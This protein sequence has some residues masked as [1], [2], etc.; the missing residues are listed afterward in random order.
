M[1]QCQ[2]PG[3]NSERR[4]SG[5][6][7]R[8]AWFWSFG[9]VLTNGCALALSDDFYV[10]NSVPA[11]GAGSSLGGTTA[12]ATTGGTSSTSALGGTLSTGVGGTTANAQ[13]GLSTTA[14]DT[15]GEP[16]T[17]GTSS[18]SDTDVTGGALATGG[19]SEMGGDVGTGGAEET[20]GTA[21]VGG[22]SATGGSGGRGGATAT[23]GT[24]ATGGNSEYGGSTSE[25]GGSH[26]SGGWWANRSGGA[27]TGGMNTGGSAIAAT[28]GASSPLSACGS[29]VAEGVNCST[30]GPPC[31]KT[32]GPSG[33]GTKTVSCR[34]TY[35]ES[36][37]SFPDG[38]DY[39][40]FA[41]P[42]S[43]PRECP[44]GTIPQATVSCQVTTCKVCFGGT[45]TS[46]T[47]KDSTGAVKTGYC[48]CTLDGVW[49]C[50]TA[51]GSWPCPGGTGCT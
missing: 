35:Q 16:A 44:S 30:Y 23:G 32:C 28:G 48:V 5:G 42:T 10:E 20:G 36:D 25:T 51:P 26:T 22:N 7:W 4:S 8:A 39:S 18:T 33:I 49:T 50:G 19:T 9:C 43:L 24:V 41:V 15:G 45:P 47:Y 29:S 38:V 6:F 27:D 13:G 31:I 11:G 2:L 1:A 40:C 37:C 12:A 17:G 14:S 21:T 3:H 46:P 34:G